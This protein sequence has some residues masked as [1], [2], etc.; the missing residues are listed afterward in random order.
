VERV[1]QA[2]ILGM[3]V[4]LGGEYEVDS[5]KESGYG[6]YDISIIPKD[7][8]KKAVIMELKTIDEFENETRDMA[9]QSALQQINERKYETSVLK[10]GIKDILKIGVVFDGKRVWAKQ[11]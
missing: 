5:E 10:R 4:N 11:G 7:K 6:R 8:S 3:L 1:Y 2:F 9:L